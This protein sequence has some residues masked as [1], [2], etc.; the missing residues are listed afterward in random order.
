[1]NERK[2]SIIVIALLAVS[3]AAA[4]AFKPDGKARSYRVT[5]EAGSGQ[6]ASQRLLRSVSY[7]LRAEEGSHNGKPAW[8][9]LRE[10]VTTEKAKT[11]WRFVVS[12]ETGGVVWVEKTVTGPDGS[13]WEESRVSFA[14]LKAK[15]NRRVYHREMIP[16]IGPFL[17]LRPNAKNNIAL[18]FNSERRPSNVSLIVVGEEK[19]ST[20]AG[21]F[22][23][24]KI[25]MEYSEEDLP[26]FARYIPSA[27][28]DT[29]LTGYYL[30]VEK[31]APHAM[32]K[33]GG[34]LDGPGAPPVTEELV[35]VQ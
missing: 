3:V 5:R 15:E 29:L 18:A 28:L 32:I 26:S 33:M 35:K 11:S 34:K 31:A 22:N 14:H 4:P 7:N 9:F 25:S 23:C 20:P 6:P 30:W 12:R 19:I 10:D 1:M 21:A 17:D 24:V 27:L 16:M 2:L 8:V 13:L